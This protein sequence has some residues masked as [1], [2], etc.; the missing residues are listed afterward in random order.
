MWFSN[1][2][3]SL[4]LHYQICEYKII[5]STTY[6]HFMAVASALKS[7][8]FLTLVVWVFSLVFISLASL[9]TLLLWFKKG[10]F[11]YW[12]YFHDFNFTVFLF[13]LLFPFFFLPWVYFDL[14]FLLSWGS[15]E[16]KTCLCQKSKRSQ[17]NN[18]SDQPYDLR[19]G[20]FGPISLTFREGRGA[21]V[22]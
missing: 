15:T 9:L 22:E 7:V 5:C 21:G 16:R 3:G 8:S 14:L 1:V 6:Y 2:I 17:T 20:S 12:V 10:L 4:L 13:Y 19:I 11:L 18:R